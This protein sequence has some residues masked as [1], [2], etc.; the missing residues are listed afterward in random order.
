MAKGGLCMKAVNVLVSVVLAAALV[1][2]WPVASATSQT[3]AVDPA[4]VAELKMAL[5]DLLVGHIVWA[6]SLA[7]ATRLGDQAAAGVASRKG[8]ENARAVGM[9]IAPI[10]GQAAGEMFAGLF[11]AHSG[12]VKEYMG[13]AFA[14]SEVRKKAAVAKMIANAE[15]IAAFLSSANPN[16]SKDAVKSLLGSH[17]AHHVA[18][19]GALA[20]KDYASEA[21]VWDATLR[22]VYEIADALAEAI[23]K[24][25]PSR[26]SYSTILKGG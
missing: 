15:E 19:L 7:F 24:Q 17:A 21:N 3:P 14:G 6:R 1:T 25:F 26:F 13:A 5:R 2:A 20:R 10:Y 11:T 12:G 22:H 8:L 18:Q 4:K 9:S 16:L 23:V